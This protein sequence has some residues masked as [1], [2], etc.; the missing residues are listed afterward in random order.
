[1]PFLY[2]LSPQ[3]TLSIR[4]LH[5]ALQLLV[6]KHQSLRTSLTFDAEKNLLMQRIIDF[7][8]DNNQLFA[9]VESIFETDEQ[10]NDILHEEKRNSQLFDLAQGLVFRCHVVYYKEISANSVLSDKDVLILNFHHALF[11]FPSMN[12][13]LDDLNQAYSTGQLTTDD[14]TTLRYLDCEY[15]Y[16]FFSIK[17]APLF[18]P[19]SDAL[20]EQQMP[21]TAANMFW[22]DT[23]HDC[24]ID[25]VVPLPFDRYRLADEHRTGRGTSVSFDF[26]EDLSHHFLAYALS[27][28]IKPQH[29]ALAC[30]YAFLFKLTNGE[31]DLCIG[32]NT[33]GR[34]KVELMSIIGTFVNTIPL[35][36]QLDPHW[37]FHQLVEHVREIETNSL[38]YSYFP[39]QR[40]LAQHPNASKPAFLDTS[41]FFHPVDNN[42]NKNKVVVGDSTLHAMPFS[43]KISEDEIMSKFDFALTFQHDININQYSCTINASLDLFDAKTVEKIAQRFRSMLEQLFQFTID[44]QMNKSISEL[45]L[46]LPD[47]RLIMQ[48]VNNTE[49]SFPPISCIHHE[50]ACQVMKHPQK[51]AVELDEQSL[52]YSE[53]L[54]YVQL[55]SLNLLNTY[56][57]IAGEIVCQSV[58]RS[59]S[60][61][62]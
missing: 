32:M 48:S 59:L 2:R 7:N 45:L 61:V 16:F 24:K 57:V 42:K 37:T 28:N 62:S 50:F 20:I 56:G 47:E 30:Y 35:R 51:L 26:G 60:M 18:S 44:D 49:V 11:D 31:K 15:K 1:M 14:D 22:L 12:V 4:Q 19:Y 43:I 41:F 54:Y 9:F 40:I 38:E 55:L 33:H 6:T 5:Q 34:Y 46:I 58:K 36:C 10:L 17:I 13:F 8:A 53:L 23:L 52:T 3:H 25:R 27:K 21:M 39:L 29:L